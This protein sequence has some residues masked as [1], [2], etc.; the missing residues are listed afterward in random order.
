MSKVRFELNKAGVRE[1]LKAPEM[2]SAVAEAAAKVASAASDVAGG[3]YESDARVGPNRAV[4][5]VRASDYRSYKSAL[6]HNTF[7][8]AIGSVH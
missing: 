7:E 3:S 2:V 1:L 5:I 8:K 4:A 6:K